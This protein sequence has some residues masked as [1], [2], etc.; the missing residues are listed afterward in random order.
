[1]FKLKTRKAAKKRY[2]ITKNKKILACHAFK[3]HLLNKK[4]K[5]TKRKLSRSFLINTSNKTP[6]KLMLPYF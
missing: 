4:S 1:M 2:K 3:S 5:K 6:I